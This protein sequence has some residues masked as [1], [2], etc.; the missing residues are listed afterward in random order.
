MKRLFIFL[1]RLFAEILVWFI[2]WKLVFM[3]YNGSVGRGCRAVDYLSVIWHGLPLDIATASYIIAP[4]LLV[5]LLN[6]WVRVPKL[7]SVLKIYYAVVAIFCTVVSV[8]DACLY[9]FW[10]YKIDATIFYY[11]SSPASVTS[12]VSIGYLVVGILAIVLWSTLFFLD[13][14]R[15]TPRKFDFL[16]ATDASQLLCSLCFWAA[17]CSLAF[18]AEWDVPQPMWEWF[19]S[20]TTNF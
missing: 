2:S 9:S 8:A 14:R 19:I 12:S 3:I 15:C 4:I 5:V 7:R 11:L 18:A 17:S 1:F 20:A 13:L 16:L 6:T 10:D